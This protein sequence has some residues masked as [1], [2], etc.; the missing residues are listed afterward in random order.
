[1]HNVDLVQVLH[2]RRNLHSRLQQQRHV[3]MP[4]IV[5]GL[6]GGL[7]LPDC[8]GKCALVAQLHDQHVAGGGGGYIEVVLE[9]VAK[10]GV[11]GMCNVAATS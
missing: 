1:M 9:G 8:V 5:L 10:R 2:R 4:R 7:T 6:E 3:L 11:L